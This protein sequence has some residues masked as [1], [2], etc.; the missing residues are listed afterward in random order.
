[1]HQA[2]RTI[3]G[4]N[5]CQKWKKFALFFIVKRK[6]RGGEHVKCSKLEHIQ[7]VLKIDILCNDS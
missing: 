3:S 1:M 4:S 7:A 6:Y 5:F 2:R